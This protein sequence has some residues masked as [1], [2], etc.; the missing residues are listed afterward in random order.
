MLYQPKVDKLSEKWY[1]LH[2][3]DIVYV[4]LPDLWC[5][6]DY[7]H[8]AE[9]LGWGEKPCVGPYICFTPKLLTP[10]VT[11][12]ERCYIFPQTYFFSH[13]D[14]VIMFLTFSYIVYWEKKHAYLRKY[15]DDRSSL[16]RRRSVWWLHH[17]ISISSID[18][19][20]LFISQ[21]GKKFQIT[22][23]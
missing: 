4:C 20:S 19:I 3:F 15:V 12:T 5:H 14:N 23:S 13:V 17:D 1:C 9:W 10:K 6:H 2:I 16:N 11:S 22:K 21:W 8:L 7:A 18:R